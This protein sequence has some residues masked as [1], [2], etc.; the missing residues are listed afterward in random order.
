MQCVLD[1]TRAGTRP[2]TDFLRIGAA[3]AELQTIPASAGHGLSLRP[4]QGCRSGKVRLSRQFLR[5]GGGS[6]AYHDRRQKWLK[7]VVTGRKSRRMSPGM[8]PLCDRHP[9]RHPR[10]PGLVVAGECL[11]QLCRVSR[12]LLL[13][14]RSAAAKSCAALRALTRAACSSFVEA[15]AAG[16]LISTSAIAQDGLT[17][18]LDADECPLRLQGPA[19]HGSIKSEGGP[20]FLAGRSEEAAD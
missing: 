5:V 12:T 3:V 8:P 11:Q 4:R 15:A 16:A 7:C 17:S 13:Q 18:V 20:Q 19:C 9:Y 6:A 10:A 14:S 2:G 1:W